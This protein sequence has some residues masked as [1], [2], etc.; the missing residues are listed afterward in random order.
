MLKGRE[1]RL[2]KLVIEARINEYMPRSANPHVPY[3]PAEIAVEAEKACE[4]GA[5]IVHFH[6]RNSDGTPS[7]DPAMYA[8]AIRAIRARCDCLV[9]PTLGQISRSG[10]AMARLRHIEELARDPATRPDIAPIDTGSTNIDRFDVEERRYVTDNQTYRNDTA[11]L[12]AFAKRLPELGVKPQ[13]VSWTIAFT[14]SFDALCEMGLVA[15]PAYLMFELTDHG[16]LGGHPGTIRGLMAHLE[17]MPKSPVEWTVCNKVGNLMGPA[18]ASIELGGHVAV[19]LGDYGWPELG[20]PDNGGVVREIARLARAMGREIARP[21][22]TR[23]MFGL[24]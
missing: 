7:H 8:E 16:I 2:K 10:D 17:F 21:A 11:T 12:I 14:R 4:A 6:A 20:S 24:S 1:V 15:E 3:T 19:G 9:F 18:A 13:F 23:A 5:S 22:D